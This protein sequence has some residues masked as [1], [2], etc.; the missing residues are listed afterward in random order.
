MSD[1]IRGG[2]V[3]F[4]KFRM[5]AQ[6]AKVL[7]KLSVLLLI[8]SMIFCFWKNTTASDWKVGLAWLKKDLYLGSDDN[9]TITYPDKYGYD[10]TVKIR[11]LENDPYV[12][13]VIAG[14]ERTFNNAMITVAII[15]VMVIGGTILFFYFRGR[16]IKQSKNIRGIFALTEKNLKAQI[17]KHNKEFKC[18]T[19]LNIAD[20]V[21]LT[22]YRR[23]IVNIVI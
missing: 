14:F 11:H 7:A 21:L 8:T 2:Q 12:V 18:Y 1:L 15:E 13:S 4:H 19:P 10:K 5:L 16:N 23:K 6:V 17:V 9:K 20:L 22:K 3:T